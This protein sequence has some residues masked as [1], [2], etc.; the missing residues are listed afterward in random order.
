M[1][2][3]IIW[4]CSI[5]ARQENTID[6]GLDC[7]SAQNACY[8]RHSFR[9]R[10]EEMRAKHIE[11]HYGHRVG[12]LRAAVLGANDGVV[13]V[14]SL[15]VGVASGGAEGKTLLLT[16]VAG[17]IAGAMSMAAGEYVSVSS[18]SD[19]EAADIAREKGE[20]ATNPELEMMELTKHY[21]ER[22]L[23]DL[24]AKSVAEKLMSVDALKAHTRDELGI[25]EALQA[26]P[27]QAAASSAAAFSIGAA[28]PLLAAMSATAS[29]VS[30]TPTLVSVVALVFLGVSSAWAGGASKLKGAVRV[31]F[32]GIFA[33]ALTAVAGK[34]FGASG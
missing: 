6:G 24:L 22:G 8:C 30:L 19:T 26:R 20:L 23:D 34:F 13:S 15:I 32:W 5:D 25:T 17:L 31:T 14:A 12:W 3:E 11:L 27:I 7:N 4:R 29:A 1:I 2:L 10:E 33:M 21:V 28:I 18:Q 16:G 9:K